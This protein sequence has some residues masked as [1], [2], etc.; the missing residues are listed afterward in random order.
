MQGRNAA[1]HG[2][3]CARHQ[4]TG[5]LH[6]G[7][8][9][10]GRPRHRARCPRLYPHTEVPPAQPRERGC[11]QAEEKGGTPCRRRCKPCLPPLPATPAP[12][13]AHHTFPR[14]LEKISLGDVASPRAH[15]EIKK[16][17]DIIG[18]AGRQ[19]REN[20]AKRLANLDQDEADPGDDEGFGDIDIP[21]GGNR[22]FGRDAEDAYYG[23]GAGV[24]ED[25]EGVERLRK[26]VGGGRLVFQGSRGGSRASSAQESHN[27][28]SGSSEER[29]GGP[30]RTPSPADEL[31]R[32]QRVARHATPHSPSSK[33][34][35]L[36]V[37]S[38]DQM[39]SAGSMRSAAAEDLDP[40]FAS[41][42]KEDKWASEAGIKIGDP[43]PPALHLVRCTPGLQPR[44]S[45]SARAVEIIRASVRSSVP[46][47]PH[48]PHPPLPSLVHAP[49]SNWDQLTRGI[50]PSQT[51]FSRTPAGP[52]RK[53]S[54]RGAAA[55]RRGSFTTRAARLLCL[56]RR[57][58]SPSTAARPVGQGQTARG[59]AGPSSSHRTPR[60]HRHL[61][62][63][64]RHRPPAEAT[65]VPRSQQ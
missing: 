27:G 54:R 5:D 18:T 56:R 17:K 43:P 12:P 7:S 24:I 2:G 55:E 50:P 60:K 35:A 41:G 63:P 62:A 36:S 28:S 45:S 23:S 11:G 58:R 9:R 29:R 30:V 38:R 10:R 3:S 19:Q 52:R 51:T 15:A 44:T 20:L 42:A 61:W 22:R 31:L 64:R 65:L 13:V 47:N 39:S 32:S 4:Y 49:P 6:S 8:D 48:P 33:K 25:G 53:I 1:V 46:P 40:Q 21:G 14:Q 57:P 59:A 37:G 34:K 26:G 16:T